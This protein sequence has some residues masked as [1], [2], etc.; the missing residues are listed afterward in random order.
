VTAAIEGRPG[1]APGD[2]LKL[3]LYGYLNRIRSN[4]AL[5]CE[6]HRHVELMWL[7]KPLRPDHKI[8]ADF[9][10]VHS[11]ARRGV[12]RQFTQLCKELE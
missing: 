11:N 5:E 12:C 10:K 7:L 6:T 4:R 8:I 2:R 9:R 1:Y 3:Y